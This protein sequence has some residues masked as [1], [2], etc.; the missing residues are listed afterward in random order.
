MQ[1]R[2]IQNFL[3]ATPQLALAALDR[4]APSKSRRSRRRAASPR[5]AICGVQPST[6]TTQVW[7]QLPSE[8]VGIC[9][10]LIFR[11]WTI[12]V[13]RVPLNIGGDSAPENLKR[14]MGNFVAA[15]TRV[16]LA[17][18]IPI[19][20]GFDPHQ[21]FQRVILTPASSLAARNPP[22][23][24]VVN[25]VGPNDSELWRIAGIRGPE[26]LTRSSGFAMRQF[27]PRFLRLEIRS[28]AT[29]GTYARLRCGKVSIIWTPSATTI[30]GTDTAR[31][32]ENSS[33]G[34]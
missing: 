17:L 22:K 18:N 2:Q 20:S 19:G 29:C 34:T 14:A 6:R 11:V 15:G 5:Q 8:P 27:V 4:R 33:S 28:I 25:A 26:S 30:I 24:K 12:S 3:T 32:P 16:Y 21:M 7:T 9:I 13:T 1:A 31:I 10:F 23:S